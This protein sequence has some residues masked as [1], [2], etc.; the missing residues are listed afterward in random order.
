MNKAATNIIV[1]LLVGVS[2]H[3]CWVDIQEWNCWVIELYI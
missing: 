2:T 3:F 1:C